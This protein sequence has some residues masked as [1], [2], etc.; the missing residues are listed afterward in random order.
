MITHYCC[1]TNSVL[2]V[3]KQSRPRQINIRSHLQL[4]L[5]VL[6]LSDRQQDL[7]VAQSEKHCMHS[8][9][10]ILWFIPDTPVPPPP[11]L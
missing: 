1:V 6:A 7:A 3:D 10:P 11:P 9:N 2:Y 8:V 5:R 4:N